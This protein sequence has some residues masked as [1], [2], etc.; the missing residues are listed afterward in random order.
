M[1]PQIETPPGRKAA[2]AL[3]N[4]ACQILLWRSE[5]KRSEEAK[6][7]VNFE[8]GDILRKNWQPV[9]Y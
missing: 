1:A 6:A 5:Y 3:I 2:T 4:Y 7:I 9:R 8:F